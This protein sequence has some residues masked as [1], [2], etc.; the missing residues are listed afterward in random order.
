M[1]DAIRNA[2]LD[3]DPTLTD[4]RVIQTGPAVLMLRLPA[5]TTAGNAHA[6]ASALHA[7][8]K[9]AAGHIHC[10]TIEYGIDTPFD[11]K[12]RRVERR[13]HPGP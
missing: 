2:V 9:Q 11:R 1:P 13:W 12:L 8:I 3:A 6:I 4:F 10:L 7:T 5:G